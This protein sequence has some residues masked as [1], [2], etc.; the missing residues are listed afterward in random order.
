MVKNQ[1]FLP[2]LKRSSKSFFT[3]CRA[4]SFFVAFSVTSVVTVLCDSGQRHLT[5]LYNLDFLKQWD[6]VPRI[7]DA[8]S[9]EDKAKAIFD[10]VVAG[11]APSLGRGQGTLS[12]QAFVMLHFT[13]SSNKPTGH[14]YEQCALALPW[15]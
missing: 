13:L 4:A 14:Y 5:K 12:K 15:T 1:R 8:L 11:Q 2:V 6:I 10:A 3:S 9:P 7:Q